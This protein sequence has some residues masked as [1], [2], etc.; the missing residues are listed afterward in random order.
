M[1]S[2][3]GK[4]EQKQFFLLLLLNKPKTPEQYILKNKNIEKWRVERGLIR[5]LWIQGEFSEFSFASYISDLEQDLANW[6]C[7]CVQMKK[8]KLH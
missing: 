6:K 8:K 7:Q 1:N 3:S 4:T 5:E 2:T